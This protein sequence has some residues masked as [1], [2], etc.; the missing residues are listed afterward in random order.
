M[1]GASGGPTENSAFAAGAPVPT[2]ST[3]FEIYNG[4][5]WSSGPSMNTAVKNNRGFG[6]S[7]DCLSIGGYNRIV[8]VERFDGSSWAVADSMST[9]RKQFASANNNASGVS[10]GW[11]GGGA[12]GDDSVEEFSGVATVQTVS[13]S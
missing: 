11:V 10:N 2:T 6:S 1:E 12:D 5:A 7:A 4:S 3:R 8:G 13:S 9:G